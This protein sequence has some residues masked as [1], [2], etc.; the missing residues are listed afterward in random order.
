MEGM[1]MNCRKVQNLMSAYVDSELSGM[2]MLALRQHLSGCSDCS[3]EYEGI[4]GTKRALGGMRPVQPSDALAQR[5]CMRLDLVAPPPREKPL[6]ALRK[7]F[8]IFP[9]RFR[10]A[11]VGM[12]V[13]ALLLMLRSGQLVTES[14][15]YGMNPMAYVNSMSHDDTSRAF[16]LS[17]LV[18]FQF[19]KPPKSASIWGPPPAPP[20][21]V[22]ALEGSFTSFAGMWK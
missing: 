15:P 9:V 14:T 16:S 4:R 17:S 7:H 11:A 6:A 18:D 19:H 20:K 21:P 22:T 3:L 5:I 10:F 1:A 8:T 12:G 2:E 13:F